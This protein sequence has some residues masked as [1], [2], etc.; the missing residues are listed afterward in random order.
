MNRI[1]TGA[2]RILVIV[3]VAALSGLDVNAIRP[4]GSIPVVRPSRD[5]MILR[6][7]LVPVHL[8]T[9]AILHA[10]TNVLFV[11]ARPAN[12]FRRGHVPR[13]MNFPSESFDSLVTEF[14]S[15]V[16][17]ERPLVV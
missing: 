14:V 8:D 4:Q 15:K 13:A 5:D 17:L 6:E 12:A 3:T 16:P 11:D 7:G 1:S 10:D 9:A 2:A